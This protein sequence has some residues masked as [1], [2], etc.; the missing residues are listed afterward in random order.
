MTSTTERP[1]PLRVLF[2]IGI[3]QN[4]F[5]L[6]T[7]TGGFVWSAFL[8]MM[9]RLGSMPGVRVIGDM[10]D[11]GTMVGP[12]SGWPW[13]CYVLADVVDRETVVAVCN[14]F[15]IV[16][17]GEHLLWRYAQIEARVGRAL[18]VRPDV[19]LN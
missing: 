2:C 13:T 4:F 18:V 5:D 7:G 17:A 16:P 1:Q 10:D 3:N 15:R 12:S 8:D 6:P 14:L 19:Q 9:E 11:D